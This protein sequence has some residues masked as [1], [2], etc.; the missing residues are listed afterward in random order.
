[1]LLGRVNVLEGDITIAGTKYHID[2]GDVSFNNPTRIEPVLNVEATARIRDYDV[3]LGVHGVPPDHL[4]SS[5]RSDPP[6]PESDVIALLALGRT[7]EE[8]RLSPQPTQ[9]YT[10]TTSNAILGEA[11]NETVSNRA[12]KLFGLG[13]IKIDP[14][15]G[16]PESNPNARLTIEQQVSDK[17][18]LTYI[19]NLSQSAQQI[20]QVEYNVDRN[21]TII[22]VRDQN[23]VLGFDVRYR[24]RKR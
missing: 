13:R 23:G 11:L 19:T 12:Q 6:L 5:Y 21:F 9:N 10:E 8:S 15:A 4:R 14:Q 7:N 18:T 17:V 20:I 22:A 1:V 16:G 2:R 24:R 3:S